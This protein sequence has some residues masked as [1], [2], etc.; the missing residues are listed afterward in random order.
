M[1]QIDYAE[2]RHS[3]YRMMT[4]CEG[5]QSYETWTL[6][7]E[8]NRRRGKKGKRGQI[9]RCTFCHEFHIGRKPAKRTR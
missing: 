4:D 9:Y 6:A 8:I 2:G 1:S 7:S 5:K 3:A